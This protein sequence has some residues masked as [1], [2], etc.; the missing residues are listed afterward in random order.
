MPIGGRKRRTAPAPVFHLR[1]QPTEIEGLSKRYAVQYDDA[2]ALR[3]GKQIAAGDYS[4]ANLETIFRWKTRNRG[5]SRLQRNLDEDIADTLW[6]AA[7]AKTERAALAV[8][9]GLQGVRYSG[10]FRHSH[11]N[12]SRPLH[13]HRFSRLGVA[14]GEQTLGARG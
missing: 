6:L 11:R 8:L 1:F 2:P 14:G 7:N 9:C 10:R 4:R 3:A 13:G 5:K 12:K